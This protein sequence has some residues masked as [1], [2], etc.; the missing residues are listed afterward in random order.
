M[1]KKLINSK[2]GV[3]FFFILL[4]LLLIIFDIYNPNLDITTEKTLQEDA[5]QFLASYCYHG[6]FSDF[7]K[8][9]IITYII[10]SFISISLILTVPDEFI[11]FIK[12]LFL[13]EALI[14]YFFWVFSHKYC[15]A[16]EE[17]IIPEFYLG[18]LFLFGVQ[19]L[20]FVFIWGSNHLFL[21]RKKKSKNLKKMPIILYKCPICQKDFKS[22][23]SYCPICQ[24][25]IIPKDFS[26]YNHQ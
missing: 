5:I 12:Y 21:I 7:W 15:P 25:D 11:K 24:K 13:I 22:N 3:I 8:M 16:F 1:K 18:L 4:S 17:L 10:I 9:G 23:V 19:I 2:I 6:D 26:I 20:E 14:H